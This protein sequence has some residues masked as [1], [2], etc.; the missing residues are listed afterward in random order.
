MRSTLG[1]R[2]TSFS[3]SP[4]SGPRLQDEKMRGLAGKT[5]TS[6][7]AGRCE[8]CVG[9]QLRQGTLAH[10]PPTLRLTSHQFS[11]HCSDRLATIL[12]TPP[13]AYCFRKLWDVI[14]GSFRERERERSIP[15][16][17]GA[18][19]FSLSLSLS[20]ALINELTLAYWFGSP[21]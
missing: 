4:T 5:L 15:R 7:P 1:S 16:L 14:S 21:Q 19:Y 3:S 11:M 20:L 6:S 18:V 2:S 17:L 13:R 12:E 8:S 10:L 9:Q